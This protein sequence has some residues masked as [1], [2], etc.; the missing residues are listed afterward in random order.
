MVQTLKGRLEM[1]W[2]EAAS[3]EDSNRR[4]RNVAAATKILLGTA[5]IVNSSL[6]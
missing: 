2:K 1:L 6:R 5:A 4:N 3:E